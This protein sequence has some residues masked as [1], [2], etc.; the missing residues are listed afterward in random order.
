M[1]LTAEEM[2]RATGG[3]W[4]SA[5]EE[6]IFA[7][8]SISTD[9]RTLRAGDVFVALKGERFDG[10]DH[11]ETAAQQGASALI[12]AESHGT[13]GLPPGLPAL[14]VGDTLRALGDLAAAWRAKC[15]ARRISIVGS[16]GKTTTK[17]MLAAILA[18]AGPV[19]ASAGNFNNLIGLPLT[20]L[21]MRPEHQYAVLELGMNLPGELERLTEIANPDML[22][23]VNV[24]TAHIGQFGSREALL[25]AKA[26]AVRGLRPGVPIL[27]NRSC[28]S[29]RRILE[30]WGGDHPLLTFAID[31]SAEI[32]GRGIRTL[33]SGGYAFDLQIGTAR[34]R[35]ELPIF[36]RYN[37]ANAVAAAGAAHAMGL[38]LSRISAA[39]ASFRAASM[40][41]E[42]CEVGGIAWIVDCYNANPESMRAA[43]QS[44]GE[45][46]HEGGKTWV[47]L[48][49]MLEL[50]AESGVLH[51]G[52]ASDIARLGADGVFLV[53]DRTPEILQAW[54]GSKDAV[55]HYAD[56]EL[57]CRDLAVRIRPGD[58]V[59]FKGSRGNKLEQIAQFLMAQ[60]GHDSREKE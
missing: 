8:E 58:R 38:D 40:R 34:E 12:V 30:K 54:Q 57:L 60:Y 11:L 28:E 52:L 5:P 2:V 3:R 23:L 41:S 49:D 35:I 16:S 44:L 32:Q 31:Q 7:A 56:R 50:G 43:L 37:I 33:A 4:R 14:V 51:R 17:E 21:Q 26:E 18:S 19:L 22:V 25:E 9:T 1:K 42:V 29:S 20:V 59:F 10:H 48:G 24:G 13:D 55:R 53:G 15:P 47:V 39:L 36:G 6:G 27:Y 46:P 45:W